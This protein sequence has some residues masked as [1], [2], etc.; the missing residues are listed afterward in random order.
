MGAG[1][2][3]AGLL[4]TVGAAARWVAT[5][6]TVRP[7]VVREQLLWVSGEGH[8]GVHTFRVPLV[9]ATRGGALVACAEGRKRSAADVGAKF[10]ACRHSPDGGATWGPTRVAADD[11][12]AADGLNLG[13]LAVVGDEVLLLFARC[14]HPPQACGPPSTHLLRSRDGGRSWGPPQNLS[15]VVGSEVFAPGPGYG[16]QKQHAPGNGRL[17]F[18]GHGTLERDGVSLLLS[19]DG[20]LRWRRG[21]SLPAI[22]F[23]APRHPRDFTPDECQPYELPDGSIAVNIRNQNSYRCRC[24]MVA[25]SWDGGETLPPA[26]V[27]FDPALVDPAVAAGV[28]VTGDLVFFSNPAHESQREWERGELDPALE[29]HQWHHVVGA[30][31]AG[32][33][34]AQWVLF[35]G[36]PTPW[37]SGTR[38][39]L[40]PRL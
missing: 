1:R 20:G 33:G 5:P 36:G 2:L 25:R 15:G 27:T 40:L 3:L 38:P 18:C 24:R 21:G 22:P 26:A 29:L 31:P 13:A 19:D 28:L 37:C 4:L 16:I 30:W 10:I 12:S 23:G 35:D 14:A 32:V 9:A 6:D 39:F 7:R 17:V 8:G 11:G 34:G